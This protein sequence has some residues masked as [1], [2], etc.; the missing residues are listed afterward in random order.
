MIN[1]EKN[2]NNLALQNLGL[3][4]PRVQKDKTKLSILGQSRFYLPFIQ[5]ITCEAVLSF[6]LLASIA[7][8]GAVSS[9]IPCL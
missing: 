6:H 7:D 5:I 3:E 1:E 4:V 8:I 9:H 2:K